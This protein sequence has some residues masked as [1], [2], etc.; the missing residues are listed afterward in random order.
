MCLGKG[1]PKAFQLCISF[2]FLYIRH[3]MHYRHSNLF[4]TKPTL[5]PIHL[6]LKLTHLKVHSLNPHLY[7]DPWLPSTAGYALRKQRARQCLPQRDHNGGTRT[8]T[9]CR[10][11][12]GGAQS[13][14]ES[15]KGSRGITEWQRLEGTSAGQLRQG[16][17]SFLLH[18]Y[19]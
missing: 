18:S 17:S 12:A 6:K 2:F 10:Y 19:W 16:L 15:A 3:Y 9:A 14:A 8:E 7:F 4:A 11:R 1:N 13:T 5:T